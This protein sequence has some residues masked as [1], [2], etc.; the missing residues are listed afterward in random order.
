MTLICSNGT[1]NSNSFLLASIFPVFRRALETTIQCQDP[2]LIFIPDMDVM[3]LETFLQHLQ[4]N[5]SKI[6]IS[7]DVRDLLQLQ[8]DT[9]INEEVCHFEDIADIENYSDRDTNIEMESKI[10]CELCGTLWNSKEA[11][12]S[13]LFFSSCSLHRPAT[14]TI[15]AMCVA[16]VWN[17]ISPKTRTKG[18]KPNIIHQFNYLALTV[19]MKV[20]LE[21]PSPK[22]LE[23]KV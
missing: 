16:K 22:W 4:E 10:P 21:E 11:G 2:W 12:K 7:K 15:S 13:D 1:V 3:D 17:T 9:A 14:L 20:F 8:L 6:S 5:H 23:V 19:T 18:R